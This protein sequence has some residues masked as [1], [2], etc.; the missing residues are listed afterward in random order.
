MSRRLGVPGDLFICKAL[1]SKAAIRATPPR[2][3][4]RCEARGAGGRVVRGA[5]GRG[6]LRSM[7]SAESRMENG[8][9]AASL[10]E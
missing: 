1:S 6:G 10:E 4:R 7:R 8:G 3:A 2:G 9:T 5:G